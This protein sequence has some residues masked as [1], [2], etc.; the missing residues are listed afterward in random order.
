M[1]LVCEPAP[2]GSKI[3]MVLKPTAIFRDNGQG[4]DN[5]FQCVFLAM[6][7]VHNREESI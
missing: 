6:S 2:D 5:L 3:S 7:R 4:E 1:A